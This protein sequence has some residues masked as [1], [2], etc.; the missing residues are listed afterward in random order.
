MDGDAQDVE[1]L[2]A[3]AR[4]EAA[5]LHDDPRLAP[6][7]GSRGAALRE[8]VLDLLQ[9]VE[10]R[11]EQ[12]PRDKAPQ[13]ARSA[14]ARNMRQSIFMLRGAQAALPWLTVTRSPTINMGSL[15]LTEECA[16]ILVGRDVDLVMVASSQFMYT[17]TS[18]PF[19]EVI[20]ATPGFSPSASRLPIVLN[21]PLTDSD[22]LLTHPI[23]SHEMGH[24]S[25]DRF[26]L[27]AEVETALYQDIEFIEE[28]KRLIAPEATRMATFRPESAIASGIR[29]LLRRWIEELLCDCLAIEVMG[30][31]FIWA[32]ATFALPFGYG[33]PAISH[34]PNTLRLH[35]MLD[36]LEKGGWYEYMDRAAPKATAWLKQI[37]GDAEHGLAA[38]PISFLLRQL[39][40]HA[41]AICAVGRDR[42]A[43]AALS[44]ADAEPEAE[45][46]AEL[47]E[48][49]ILPVGLQ[50]PLKPRAILLGGWR[51]AFRRHGDSASGIVK[52]MS[53]IGLQDL[54]GKAIELSVVSDTWNTR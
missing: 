46:A 2:L 10:H 14:F 6:Q 39:K 20:D 43:S 4:H 31:A 32:F 17:T 3:S 21:Y 16:R 19:A 35:L 52:A 22:R 9:A 54:I 33:E 45:E 15:Y 27:V 49:L 25:C 5:S 48:R 44:R 18:A 1:F 28:F 30:P 47:L 53:D 42:V 23:F 12:R 34:P 11:I 13:A 29:D 51:E 41:G 36:H 40:G 50:T 37:G 7:P 26:N 24:A 38:E 8:H